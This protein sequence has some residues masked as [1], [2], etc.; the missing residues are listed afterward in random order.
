MTSEMRSLI[1][2]VETSNN[3]RNI[4]ESRSN[5]AQDL[6]FSLVGLLDIETS[7]V[8]FGVNDITSV[9]YPTMV[10]ISWKC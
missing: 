7:R 1:N 8:I 2:G 5:I 3:V 10:D 6:S 9:I 4:K